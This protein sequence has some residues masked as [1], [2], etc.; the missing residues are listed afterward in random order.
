VLLLRYI[1]FVDSGLL[2]CD[3]MWAYGWVR[4]IPKTLSPFSRP[5]QPRTS[6]FIPVPL[7]T[8]DNIIVDVFHPSNAFPRICCK[9][10]Q[11][12][13]TR[14][15][16]SRLY[17]TRTEVRCICWYGMVMTCPRNPS[18]VHPSVLY[19]GARLHVWAPSYLIAHC[20]DFIQ[21]A[22]WRNFY[23]LIQH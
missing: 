12:Y 10:G 3:A 23:L 7:T 20:T 9:T 5:R 6:W 17:V 13:L 19:S 2:G 15:I 18:H 14:H 16:N 1:P 21:A 11:G 8:R 4:T 22:M